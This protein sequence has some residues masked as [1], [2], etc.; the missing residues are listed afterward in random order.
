MTLTLLVDLDDTLLGTQ[1]ESF[2]RGYIGLLSEHMQ[3]YVDPS[4]M[5]PSLMAATQQMVLN[6]RPDRTLEETFDRAFYPQLGIEKA[7][8]AG[9]LEQF[10]LDIYP[11]LQPLT[12]NVP[13][14]EFLLEE[15]RRRSWKVAIATNPLYP[16]QAILHRLSW[17]GV[18]WDQ[19]PVEIVPSYETFHFAKPNPSYFAELLGRLSWP[20]GPVIM[21][22]DAPRED[23]FGASQMG[24]PTFWIN[25]DHLEMTEDCRP[26]GVGRLA[27]FLSWLE[28]HPAETHEPDF[29]LPTALR[30]ILRATPAFFDHLARTVDES[31]WRTRPSKNEWCLTEIVCHLRDVE[32][33]VNLPR[34]RK[35]VDES[36]P[37]IAGQD[38]DIWAEERRYI[39]QDYI[40][41]LKAFTTARLEVLTELDYMDPQDWSRS[42]RHSIF[43]PTTLHEIIQ[44]MAGHDKLHIQQANRSK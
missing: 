28:D 26:T 37:F 19:P 4:K 44:I 22:G 10:Y 3:P 17:A 39:E 15:A 43:G 13:G 20:E 23:M 34:L 36:N 21:V 38:T 8:V 12:F 27:T 7:S 25:P 14:V 18:R 33:E 1:M 31:T 6:R 32:V 41:A 42:A 9:T 40:Q 2:I 29:N 35:M 24:I 16:L 5:V 11:R 30:A